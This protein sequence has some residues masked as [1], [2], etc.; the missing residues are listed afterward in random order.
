MPVISTA[1]ARF[2]DTVHADRLLRATAEAATRSIAA[3]LV[4]PSADYEYLL[5]YRP[6][7]MERLTC[8]I[9]PVEGVPALVV[10][11]LE[12]PLARGAIGALAEGIEI[13]AWE[14]TE[15]P[16]QLVKARL[17]GALRV[18]LQDQM[19][20][21]FV[22][23]LRALLDPAE[24]VDASPAIGAVRRVKQPEEVDRLRAAASAADEAML[25]I[26]A[27]RLSGRSEEEVSRRINEL[28]LTSGHDTA[29]FAIVAS[30]PN[31]ASPHH[32]PGERIIEAGDAVVLDIGGIRD[33]YCSDTTRTA[34]VGEPPAD[35]AAMYEVLR[36]AQA[37]ACAA[38]A[39]GVPARDIDRAARRII[40][41]AGYGE[42][43]MHRT[44][45]GIG[46]EVH[47]EPYIVE[48]NDEPLVA[49]NAFSIEPGIY[50]ADQWGARIED[51]VVCTDAGG[52]RLNTNSTELILVD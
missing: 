30:G 17:R 28:L 19:W 47:E 51:I 21:R 2:A 15:D 38:V 1:G 13:I 48:S 34:F 14:E 46:L 12:E 22:L 27:E 40:E 7:A 20:S 52:Q 3:L 36:A 39:P 16:F 44:G 42:A 26:T 32:S 43:F 50:I 33:A 18:G 49:G 25:A 24:L 31:S 35:F 37:A 45:H 8:L 6:P 23:R 11:R 4:T 5:G 29:E 9:L 10:P 41:E